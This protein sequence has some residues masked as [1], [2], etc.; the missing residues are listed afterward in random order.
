[1]SFFHFICSEMSVS[2]SSCSE[3]KSTSQKIDQ[4]WARV[5]SVTEKHESFQVQVYFRWISVL[6]FTE[7]RSSLLW[8]YWDLTVLQ[9]PC[10]TS[11]VDK[12][13]SSFNNKCRPILIQGLRQDIELNFQRSNI[14]DSVARWIGA[15]LWIWKNPVWF[16]V[17]EFFFT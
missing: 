2:P 15:W 14:Y 10:L 4:C 13:I 3:W 17:R 6:L 12:R 7:P 1:M 11:Y 5:S 9:N 8:S 16:P